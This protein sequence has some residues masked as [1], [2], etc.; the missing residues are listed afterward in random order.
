MEQGTDINATRVD[1]VYSAVVDAM[2]AGRTISVQAEVV[3]QIEMLSQEVNSG[4]SF[5]QYFRWLRITE[6][7]TILE[8]LKDLDLPDVCGV[9]ERAMSVAFPDGIP[10][11]DDEYEQC[12]DWSEEQEQQLTNLF[13][14]FEF[15][16]GTITN[17]LGQFI[18]QN[19]VAVLASD[20]AGSGESETSAEAVDPR[21]VLAQLLQIR[22]ADNLTENQRIVWLARQFE[23]GIGNGG[24]WRH[25]LDS[26]SMQ[27]TQLDFVGALRQLGAEEYAVILE[28][29]MA[30]IPSGLSALEA[31]DLLLE[32]GD[33]ADMEDLD[34]A[35]IGRGSELVD[36]LELY[37]VEHLEDFCGFIQ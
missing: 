28:Q 9:V 32:E 2:N 31:F 12:M 27:L 36:I 10:Q 14:E 34:A 21:S 18:E 33:V 37:V 11:D 4:A 23:C 3:Y 15:Y 29:A 5:E 16:N 17:R 1:Q 19:K 20:E 13:N 22:V 24:I 30:R 26:G 7:S 35:L 25:F 8:C 6:N